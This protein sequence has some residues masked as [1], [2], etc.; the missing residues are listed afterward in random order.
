MANEVTYAS[1]ADMRLAAVLNQ[2]I[3]LK[4][5]DRFSL[6]GHPSIVYVG[7]A[8]GSGSSTI[9]TSIVSLDGVDRMA[10]VADG[11]SV[12]N[13][14]LPNTSA[15]ITIARQALQRSVTD[16]ASITDSQGVGLN[17]LVE[18]MVGAASMRFQ[19]MIANITD[20]FSS[21]VGT[22]TVDLTVDDFFSAQFT[23]MNASNS[24]VPICLLHPVQV[25]DFINSLRGESGA[26]AMKQD[27]QAMLAFKNA[28]YQG[29]FNGIDI[30]ASSL[31]PTANAGADSAGGM[32]V[33][34]AIGYADGT[35]AA[36]VAS[37][38][39]VVPAGTKLYVEFERDASGAVTKIVGN[40]FCG[41]GELQDGMGVG[42][43]SDR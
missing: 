42:L 22:T 38:G 36:I 32:W 19:E 11:S 21:V 13:T 18:D 33:P 3:Q 10:A 20:D 31:V 26:M 15:S 17:R 23:L 6:W 5:A 8:S 27:A 24:G 7:S 39:L 14:A 1:L 16:L 28:G 34:G 9:K 12:S 37:G 2:E 30:F 41:V 25:T 4:L 29:N 40:Y 35:P 43:T